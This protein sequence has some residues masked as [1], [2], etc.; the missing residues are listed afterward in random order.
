MKVDYKVKD[1]WFN[2]SC[3]HVQNKNR[4]KVRA[5]ARVTGRSDIR[6][7]QGGVKN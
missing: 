5:R 3:V 1:H 6:A 7:W 2:I 4:I